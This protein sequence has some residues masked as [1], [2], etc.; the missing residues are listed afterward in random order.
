MEGNK[1]GRKKWGIKKGRS[2]GRQKSGALTALIRI[3]LFCWYQTVHIEEHHFGVLQ[4]QIS[5]LCDI[6]SNYIVFLYYVW[7]YLPCITSYYIVLSCWLRCIKYCLL[8]SLLPFFYDTRNSAASELQMWDCSS[9]GHYKR[10]ALR[11][12]FYLLRDHA[13]NSKDFISNH[14]SQMKRMKMPRIHLSLHPKKRV[15]YITESCW[16]RVT[17]RCRLDSTGMCAKECHK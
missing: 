8:L 7:S 9:I 15:L 3:A 1:E 5:S 17:S 12:K 16:L 6:V 14:L 10:D 11:Y 4:Y 2:K 13:L